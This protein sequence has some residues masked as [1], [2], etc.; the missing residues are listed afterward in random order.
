MKKTL[1]LFALLLLLSPV[2]SFA[3]D[4][5]GIFDRV[6]TYSHS[7]QQP[8]FVLKVDDKTL[9]FN[10]E[11]KKEISFE[12]IDPNTIKEIQVL[13]GVDAL[14][15]GE[16]T[17]GVVVITFKDFEKLSPSLKKKFEAL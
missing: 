14:A 8:T 16:S 12:K 10:N 3:Q 4:E 9:V 5:V 17:Y 1:L 2:V 6:K 15:Y 11:K 13:K 7:S